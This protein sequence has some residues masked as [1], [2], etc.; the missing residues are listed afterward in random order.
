MLCAAPALGVTPTVRVGFGKL[1]QPRQLVRFV[2]GMDAKAPGDERIEPLHPSLWRGK[3]E[4]VPYGR[5][6]RLGGRY[7]YVLSD[8]WGYPGELFAPRPPYEDFRAWREFVE[9]VAKRAR[10]GED[11][12]F[13][14]W[15]EPNHS[16]FWAATREQFHETCS[17]VLTKFSDPY[18]VGIGSRASDSPGT[19][20]LLIGTSSAVSA[21][22]QQGGDQRAGHVSQALGTRLP[23]RLQA[24]ED[25]HRGVPGHRRGS[26]G[27]ASRATEEGPP[28]PRWRGLADPARRGPAW[29]LPAALD[30][31][32][33]DSPAHRWANRVVCQNPQRMGDLFSFPN[34]VNEK[35][36]R[37]VAGAV[38][39]AAILT[40]ATGWHWLLIPLA[41]GFLAR[42]ATGPTLSPLGHIASGVIAPRLGPP[43]HV[44]GPPKRFAQGI[45]AVL[46]TAA[47]LLA[48]GFGET[49][50]ANLLLGALIVAAGLESIFALCLGC[51][52]FALLMRAGVI[53]EAVCAECADL[54]SRREARPASSS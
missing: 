41:Y 24:R 45:G 1:Q 27:E 6:N 25:R 33:G 31:P 50:A 13:D 39:A 8:R 11:L 43:K 35:A 48:L 49:A 3:L 18:V 32:L 54:W 34:P 51:K 46:T 40:L 7:T 26:A 4:D 16:H 28:D 36:A 19:A 30:P 9:K 15:N 52:A 5:A 17:R 20:Q 14:V 47:A 21:R 38:F 12:V 23:A 44:D 53:P 22:A 10:K 29:R 2:H 42:V 37:V